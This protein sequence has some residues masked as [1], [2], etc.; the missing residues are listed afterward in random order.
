MR[1][2]IDA[3]SIGQRLNEGALTRRRPPILPRRDGNKGVICQ[4]GVSGLTASGLGGNGAVFGHVVLLNEKGTGHLS[5]Q[6]G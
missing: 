3:A 1:R 5:I 4:Y 6:K 2:C